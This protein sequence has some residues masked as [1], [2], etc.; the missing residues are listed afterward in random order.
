MSL[1]YRWFP[2]HLQVQSGPAL[3]LTCGFSDQRHLSNELRKAVWLD[4]G[5][6]LSVDGGPFTKT[7]TFEFTK[8][9]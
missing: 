9:K 8:A 5:H 3:A 7:R 4:G 2:D 6:G 1:T